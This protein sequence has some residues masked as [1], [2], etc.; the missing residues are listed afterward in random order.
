MYSFLITTVAVKD[1]NWDSFYFLNKQKVLV[2][3]SLYAYYTG[4]SQ[5]WHLCPTDVTIVISDDSN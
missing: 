1:D 5:M 3:R 4:W 2:F